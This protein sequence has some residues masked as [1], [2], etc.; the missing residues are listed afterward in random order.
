[1][2]LSEASIE[3]ERALKALAEMKKREKKHLKKTH[4]VRLDNRTLISA[5]SK[6]HLE[7]LL[8]AHAK[9]ERQYLHYGCNPPKTNTK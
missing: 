2:I 1:M 6:K 9:G 7:Y 5:S 8:D 3:R 4:T